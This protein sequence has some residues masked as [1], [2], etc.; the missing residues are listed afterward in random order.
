MQD[1][2]EHN[3]VEITAYMSNEIKNRI[4]INKNTNR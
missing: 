1:Y 2:I 4:D 3:Y